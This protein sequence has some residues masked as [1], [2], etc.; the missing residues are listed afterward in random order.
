MLSLLRTH[1]GFKNLFYGQAI[2]Q[3]GDAL[4][5]V[6]F[7]FMV[8]KITGSLAMVGYVGAAETLPFFLF[9]PYS[10]VL[11]D[12]I[13]RRKILLWSDLLSAAILI[14]MAIL[15]F[16]PTLI[17]GP[18][19]FFEKAIYAVKPPQVVPAWT[20]IVAGFCLATIRTFFFPAKNASI[21]R[22]LPVEDLQRG[23][24]LSIGAQNLM[25]MIGTAFAATVMA[26]MF[27]IFSMQTFFILL[28]L[29]NA[30][31]FGGSAAFIARLPE[32]K[33][34]KEGEHEKAWPAFVS[35]L[36][37]I[38][39][40]KDLI[41]LM[42]TGMV[43]GLSVA[44]F[45]VT[46]VAANKEWFGGKPGTLAWCEFS[47][48]IGMVVASALVGK[49]SIKKP[50]ISFITGAAIVG[51]AVGLMALSK[52]FYVFCFWN[53]ICGLAVPYIDIPMRSYL[54]AT[55]PDDFRGRVNSVQSMTT[56]AVM[57]IGMASAGSL[58]KAYGLVVVFTVMGAAMTLASMIGLL[59]KDFRR[60]TMP[61]SSEMNAEE[62]AD[63]G[64]DLELATV[65]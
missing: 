38:H 25:F 49:Q 61:V 22:L 29:I 57:P 20:L 15:A 47:F 13:D 44:P 48:F 8:E 42:I 14:G 2:S 10:G 5:Y 32:I 60:A 26:P 33:P 17:Y 19:D 55:V 9:G 18:P 27:E 21:P 6:S 12:R 59:G 4:F 50:G 64:E 30:L 31:S 3:V 54:Q 56:T 28:M 43:F 52:N 35:G 1:I 7:M 41:T 51:I 53:V 16:A 58:L 24:A 40:R 46:Y 63:P 37:F 39:N 62:T 45:F 36:R 11:A 23:F 34:E 65:A